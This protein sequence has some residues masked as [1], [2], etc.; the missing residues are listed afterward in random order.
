MPC[1]ACLLEQ[2]IVSTAIALALEE[3]DAITSA[4]DAIGQAQDMVATGKPL[5]HCATHTGGSA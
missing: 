1:I 5:P 3:D 4:A 2:A